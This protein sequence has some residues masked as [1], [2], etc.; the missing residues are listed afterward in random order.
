METKTKERF[1]LRKSKKYKNVVSVGLGLFFVTAGGLFLT[2]HQAEAK[3]EVKLEQ[4]QKDKDKGSIDV[5]IKKSK[6][7]E[8]TVNKAKEEGIDVKPKAEKENLGTVENISEA[9]ELEKTA[10]D[11]EKEEKENLE[12]ETQEYKNK[13]ETYQKELERVTNENEKRKK[14]NEQI[15][16]DNENI[17]EQNKEV[18]EKNKI[19]LQHYEFEK[20]AYEEKLEEMRNTTGYEK[21]GNIR[22]AGYYDKTNEH[23]LEYFKNF[24]LA[25]DDE[26]A[27]EI[28]GKIQWNYNSRIEKISGGF[29]LS[30]INDSEKLAHYLRPG[31]YNLKNL[32][33]GDKYK[34]YN[35]GKT[36]D[37]R[38]VHLEVTVTSLTSDRNFPNWNGYMNV[39]QSD[40]STIGFDIAVFAKIKQHFKFVD[41]YGTPLNILATGVVTDIDFH[42][43]LS[44][45][46]NKSTTIYKIPPESLIGRHGSSYHDNDGGDYYEKDK[47]WDG[48]KSI[49]KGSMLMAGYGSE[50]NLTYYGGFPETGEI[51]KS[52]GTA[53]YY[54]FT[55]FGNTF[56]GETLTAPKKPYIEQ[57]KPLKPEK[58]LLKEPKKP[59]TPIIRYT[60]YK[61]GIK[62][63]TQ[64]KVTN[65]ENQNLNNRQTIKGAEVNFNLKTETL[66]KNREQINV[67]QITDTL[68]QNYKIN[69]EKTKSLNKNFLIDYS[70]GQITFTASK[71]TLEKINDIEK[72]ITPPA[73][74]IYGN[75]TNDETTIINEFNLNINNKYKTHSNTVEVKTPEKA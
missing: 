1:T 55:L 72:D 59:E 26:D 69:L 48:V 3:E 24:K 10:K 44:I 38:N 46:F 22:I 74:T 61:Y 36:A 45:D 41:D 5:N 30:K 20:R 49:P 62:P 58:E 29:T 35:V 11:K 33:V 37:G 19:K 7:F 8:N 40:D 60:E 68:P 12:K 14:E 39:G 43:G 64:K 13:K 15:R 31:A 53:P 70:K 32:Q 65:S 21:H 51:Y 9:K 16:K 54:F 67:F 28:R 25:V 18:D 4:P 17:K 42:Q 63:Q 66:P 57:G 2:T 75:I 6:E 73:P 71:Q 47:G 56:K 34:I 50:F 23:R 27:D 52:Y